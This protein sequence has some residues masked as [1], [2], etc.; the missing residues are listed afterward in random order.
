MANIQKLS[1]LAMIVITIVSFAPI[2]GFS[3]AGI[4][5]IVGIAF[6]FINNALEKKTAAENGLDE[7]K[8]RAN[9]KDKTIW[10]WIVLP[11]VM[12]VVCI[13]LAKFIL[14]EYIEHLF[15]RIVLVISFDKILL[16]VLQLAVLALGEEIAWRA[17]FQ[18][19]LNKAVSIVPTFIITSIIFALGHIAE[20]NSFVVIYDIFFIF[21]NSVIYGVIFYKTNNAWISATSHFVANLFSTMVIA[22]LQ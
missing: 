12:N 11:L 6:F 14:P 1:F 10:F 9:L 16:L 17:F 3:I 2:L 15:A 19:Q 20:G 4:S 18:K 5:I 22:F 8:I 21:V 13:G 7:K